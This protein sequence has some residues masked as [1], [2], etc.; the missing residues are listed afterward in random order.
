[1]NDC[2]LKGGAEFGVGGL[3]HGYRFV[4]GDGLRDLAGLHGKVDSNFSVDLQ[5][6]SR[7]LEG[8]EALGFGADFIISRQKIGSVVFTGLIRG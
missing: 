5:D 3:N 7:T 6:D 2:A 8:L 1:M 4:H